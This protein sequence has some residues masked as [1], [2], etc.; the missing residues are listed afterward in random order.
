MMG[1]TR[2]DTTRAVYF[3]AHTTDEGAFIA[4]QIQSGI[5][6]IQC[7]RKTTEWNGGHE[8]GAPGI[9]HWAASKLCRQTGVGVE[10]RV[11]AI[12]TNVVRT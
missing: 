9:V 12:D 6:Y 10:H 5:G 1:M 2:S 7:G 3:N 4:G 11:D 8:L